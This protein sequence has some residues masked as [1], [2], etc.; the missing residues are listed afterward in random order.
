MLGEVPVASVGPT[1]Y[2]RP[3]CGR[4]LPPNIDVRG[5]TRSLKA[6]F[7]R[8]GFV[9][10]FQF[11]GRA[12]ARSDIPEIPAEQPTQT[13]SNPQPTLC[14]LG[15]VSWNTSSGAG[16]ARGIPSVVTH[17]YEPSTWYNR[18]IQQSQII[19]RVYMEA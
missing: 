10:A 16:V 17:P 18:Q 9:Q 1:I 15:C 11:F 6:L 3:L 7:D 5:F 12:L 14:I 8:V 2:L 4:S 19:R 13:T